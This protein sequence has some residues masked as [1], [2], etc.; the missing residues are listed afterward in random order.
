MFAIT[1]HIGG[2]LAD[3]LLASGHRVRAVVRDEKKRLPWAANA[4]FG[5]AGPL[6]NALSG[7]EGAFILLP[8]LVVAGIGSI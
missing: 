8:P 5:N 2:T 4:D 3:I 7:A 6:A 1:G